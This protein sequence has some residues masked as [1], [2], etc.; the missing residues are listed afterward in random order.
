MYHNICSYH[1]AYV[2]SCCLPYFVNLTP[3]CF[4][5][6]LPICCSHLWP[7]ALSTIVA[8][9]LSSSL[10]KAVVSRWCLSRKS[11]SHFFVSKP[12]MVDAKPYL[13]SSLSNYCYA[14]LHDCSSN[15]SYIIIS[16]GIQFFVS[17]TVVGLYVP[18][19]SIC[20]S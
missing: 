15:L 3:S 16:R 10:T 4:S 14:N 19:S 20:S 13:T 11:L 18:E 17:I 5:S 12:H 6:I 2:F 7:P 9:Y 8:Y 1:S